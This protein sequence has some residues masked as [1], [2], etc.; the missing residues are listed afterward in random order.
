MRHLALAI[1]LL[2]SSA[3][4]ATIVTTSLPPALAAQKPKPKIAPC[5]TCVGTGETVIRGQLK[6]CPECKGKG[7]IELPDKP[8]PR[9]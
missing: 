4:G 3:V 5:P 7:Y 8:P 6:T 9:H 1:A 2:A